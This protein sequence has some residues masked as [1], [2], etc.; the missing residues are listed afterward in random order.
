MTTATQQLYILTDAIH[1]YKCVFSD[2]ARLLFIC[3][4]M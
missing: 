3:I 2:A 4:I 1:I